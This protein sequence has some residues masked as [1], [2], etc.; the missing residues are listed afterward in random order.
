MAYSEFIRGLEAKAEAARAV[1]GPLA[2]LAEWQQRLYLDQAEV[3]V[4]DAGRRAGKTYEFAV[5]ALE[6]ARVKK[7]ARIVYAAK[8]ETDARELLLDDLC[9]LNDDHSLGG[10]LV[11]STM[12]FPNG[13]RI[14]LTGAKDHIEAQRRFRGRGFDLVGVDECQL[15]PYLRPM[16]MDAI[17][18]ALLRGGRSGR[19]WLGGT[20]GEVAGVGFWEEIRAGVMEAWRIHVATVR[21]NPTITDPEAFLQRR[22]AELGG[23]ANPTFQRE[24]LRVQV[25]PDE[26]S[27]LVYRYHKPVNHPAGVTLVPVK[28][29]HGAGA[30]FEGLPKGKWEYLLAIDLGHTRDASSILVLGATDAAPGKGFLVEEFLFHRRPTNVIRAKEVR[31]RVDRYKPLASLCDEG[32]L[33]VAIA[34]ELRAPPHDLPIIAADKTNPLASS[35]ALNTALTSGVLQIHAQS[36]LA[37]DL[38]VLRWDLNELAKAKRK[39]AKLPHSD[40]EPCARYLWP[41]LKVLTETLKPPPPKLTL[42]EEEDARERR[43]AQKRNR[44]RAKGVW[45][46]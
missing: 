36:R 1:W 27:G 23:W 19:L 45:W 5:E 30:R 46:R 3:R 14:R 22:A 37:Q 42:D 20:P 40:V 7:A 26:A 9:K 31:Q 10:A 44:L 29:E 41:R 43:E 32:A 15:L 17:M 4:A 28:S 33:G 39:M 8:S 35:D 34:D 25:P 2:L 11:K 18:P 12:R 21:D 24:Y 16:V 13:A 38:A 6:L